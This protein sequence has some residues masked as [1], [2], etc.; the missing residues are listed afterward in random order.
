M[1]SLRSSVRIYRNRSVSYWPTLSG[2]FPTPKAY[3]I[4][5]PTPSSKRPTANAWK[6][7]RNLRCTSF[8]GRLAQILAKRTMGMS[9]APKTNRMRHESGFP[10]VLV[11]ANTR[12]LYSCTGNQADQKGK[13]WCARRLPSTPWKDDDPYSEDSSEARFQLASLNRVG[14]RIPA[15]QP[16]L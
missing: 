3:P 13:N 7:D 9:G 14:P 16:L 11:P 15:R 12:P 4:I 10:R 8:D 6:D 5:F 2:A 1:I